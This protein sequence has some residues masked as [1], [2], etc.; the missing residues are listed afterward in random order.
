[1]P[2]N[3]MD[4]F[5]RAME[6]QKRLIANQNKTKQQ[7]QATTMGGA[8]SAVPSADALTAKNT[9]PEAVDYAR[10]QILANEATRKANET[11]SA[12]TSSA[13]TTGA[14]T[15]YGP[16][17][18]RTFA[19]QQGWDVAWDDATKTISL[20]DPTTGKKL[21]MG[22]GGGQYGVGAPIDGFHQVSDP[23]L[24][25]QAMGLDVRSVE[26]MAGVTNK[27]FTDTVTKTPEG[28]TEKASNVLDLWKEIIGG[29]FAPQQIPQA[30][31]WE[32]AV[33]Q[34]RQQLDPLYNEQRRQMNENLEYG[35]ARSG[36]IG[37]LPWQMYSAE[38][39]GRLENERLGSTSSFAQ[40][41]VG[42]SQA[43]QQRMLQNEQQRQQNLF[44][45][46]SSAYNAVEGT[47]QQKMEYA[48]QFLKDASATDL[49]QQHVDLARD[50]FE[51]EA[52]VREFARLTEEEKYKQSVLKTEVERLNLEALPES[53]ALD[54]ADKYQKLELAENKEV[55]EAALFELETSTRQANLVLLQDK[56]ANAPT[57][58]ARAA[59]LSEYDMA[60]KA[61]EVFAKQESLQQSAT[62]KR[63]ETELFKRLAPDYDLYDKTMRKWTT[64]ELVQWVEALDD[65]TI[66]E[67]RRLMVQIP[68]WQ[69]FQQKEGN[70]TDIQ[71]Q[72]LI[73]AQLNSI[74]APGR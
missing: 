46:F 49:Q 26:D 37:Q 4:E 53:I 45:L 12:T 8:I 57:E 24:L 35:G 32:Q 36:L 18:L 70:L 51:A 65:L 54:I 47:E 28:T 16:N 23:N 5:Q 31:T 52:P 2:F 44:N 56:I 6:E 73:D 14:V 72:Q 58:A 33:D 62:Y 74:S 39:Q 48:M 55:R 1:M 61:L 29:N 22:A 41:L 20:V 9:T 13:A 59:L 66:E 40:Q 17:S 69:Q 11:A 30:L 71:L 21:S 63:Y 60:L 25:R 7:N 27:M 42:A 38:N 43:E 19:G 68:G 3:P 64:A 67:R 50:Q 10:Q 34:A 15:G